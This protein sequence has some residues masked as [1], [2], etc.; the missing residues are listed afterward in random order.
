MMLI[1]ESA[2][3]IYFYLSFFSPSLQE[4][5]EIPLYKELDTE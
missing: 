2:L 4:I 5:K 3:G 1:L